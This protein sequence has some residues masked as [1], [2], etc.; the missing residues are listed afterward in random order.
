[1]TILLQRG[2][3]RTQASM[4]KE[5]KADEEEKTRLDRE[6]DRELEATFPASDALNIT[7]SRP[8]KRAGLQSKKS[9]TSE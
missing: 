9:P 2:A 8:P 7:R 4:S 5:S 1:M 3:E 6:L